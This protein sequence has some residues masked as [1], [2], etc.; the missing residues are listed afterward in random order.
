MDKIILL[1]VVFTL[2]LIAYFSSKPKGAAK[3]K[4]Q[5]KTEIADTYKSKMDFE[6]MPYIDDSKM[7][8][9]K[10]TILIKS[11]ASELNRNIFFDK[12]E[13]KALVE[14]LILYEIKKDLK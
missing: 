12:N 5:K 9:Q 6:L 11:I 8:L 13:V 7:L 2:I 10:K 14:E 3:S 1:L 4:T